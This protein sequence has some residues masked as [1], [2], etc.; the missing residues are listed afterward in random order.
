MTANSTDGEMVISRK[1]Q[2]HQGRDGKGRTGNMVHPNVN[3]GY[4]HDGANSQSMDHEI[5]LPTKYI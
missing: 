3:G 4:I 1:S 2:K 5:H